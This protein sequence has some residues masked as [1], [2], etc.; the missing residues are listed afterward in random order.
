MRENRKDNNHAKGRAISQMEMLYVML[1]Y[2]EVH[3]D[4][5]FVAIPTMSFELRAGIGIGKMTMLKIMLIL[6]LIFIKD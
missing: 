4:L 1:K 3:T 2:P 5:N 6:V